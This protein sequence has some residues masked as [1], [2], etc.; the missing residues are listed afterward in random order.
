MVSQLELHTPS[1]PPVLALTGKGY[2]PPCSVCIGWGVECAYASDPQPS[3]GYG[4][5]NPDSTLGMDLAAFV[6]N[7]PGAA[8]FDLP[9]D[10]ALI[11]SEANHGVPGLGSNSPMPA[12]DQLPLAGQTVQLIDEFFARCHPQ[13][14]CP[15]ST[16]LE[17]AIL[18]TAARAHRDATVSSRADIFLQAAVDSL[19]Q[20]PLL[21]ENVSRDLQAA[22][23]YVYSLYYSGEITRAVMLLAQAYWLACLN[24]LDR[25]DEPDPNKE[26]CRGTLWALFVLD[27][28]INYLMGRHFVIDDVRWCVNYPLD[29]A[30]SQSQHGLRPDL[31][32]ERCYSSDLAAQ[33]WEKPNI[34]I[35]TALPRLVCK[36]SVMIG[37]IA[38]YKSINPMPS[39]THGAQKRQADFRELQSALACLWV[40]LPACVHNVSEVPSGC[41]NQSVWLLITL[42]TCST[43]F[44]YITD[45]ER[46]SPGSDQYPTER[47][48]FTCTYKSVNKDVTALRALSAFATDAVLNPMLAPSYF[49]CCRFILLQWRR[50]QQQEFRLDLGLLLRLLEQMADKQA[51]MAKIYKEIIEQELG[52]DLDVQGEGSLGQALVKTEY[53][54]KI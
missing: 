32:P 25:L 42:H 46:R 49:S 7:M 17:W 23:W 13:L 21:R 53:C 36:A 5:P 8:S 54:F 18:A 43:L 34:V 37:R 11:S 48:N 6:Q 30:S 15:V 29:D 38:T 20:S 2:R 4:F 47:K 52:R 45:T 28:Q 50:S 1:K 3:M 12:V 40:S 33:A 35:G 19:A 16:P 41:V 22:V 44:F 31:E 39:D 14:P 24:G 10:L 9:P 27:R 51:G 26:E